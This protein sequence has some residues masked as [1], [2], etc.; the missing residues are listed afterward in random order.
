[1]K[2]INKPLDGLR[3]YGRKVA[4]EGIVLLENN[5]VLPLVN[6]K[7]ALFGRIQTNYYKSGTGS[8]GLV[9]VTDVPS[10]VDAVLENPRLDLN[11]DVLNK[12]ETWINENPFNAGNGMWASEPWSQV[13]ME[14]N[15]EE[16]RNLKRDDEIAVMVIG[17]TAGEDR[18]NFYGEGSYLLTKVEYNVIEN[19]KKVYEKVV[20]VLN[21]GN[22]IDLNF[23]KELNVDGLLLAWHGGQDGARAS[24]DVLTGYINPSG[25]L[26]VTIVKDL[27]KYEASKTFGRD[28]EIHYLEDIY[29]GYR[30]FESFLEEEVLYPFGYGL[31]Y[32]NFEI[33]LKEKTINNNKIN[34]T[35][36]VNNI[37]NYLGKE[38]VQIYYEAPQGL[39]GKPKK[40]LIAFSKTKTIKPNESVILKISFDI[41]QMASYDDLGLIKK[42]SYVLE[43]G[44]YIIYYGNSV[45]NNEVALKYNVVNNIITEELSEALA[46]YKSFERIKAIK[47]DNKL[48]YIFEKTP[49]RLINLDERINENLPNEIKQTRNNYKLIDV[50][51]NKITLDE[52]VGTLSLEDLSTIII[53]EGMSSPK[54]TPGTA[55][56]FAGVTNELVEKGIPTLAAA[57]GPSGIRMDS[58]MIATSLPNGT[59]IAA[60]FNPSLVTKLYELEG[61][62]MINYNIDCLLG[63]GMNIQRHPLNGRNF[64]YFSEDPLL[65]GIM[66]SAFVEGLNNVGVFGAMKHF[67]AN[68]QEKA[69]SLANSIISERALR[70]IYLKPF[71]I[72]VKSANANVIMTSYNPINGI[73]TA[74]NYDLNTTI[75]RNEW[76]FDGILMTDWWAMMNDDQ[77]EPSKENFKAL[78][79]SQNDLYMVVPNAKEYKSNLLESI[80]KGEVKL[81][82]L[83]RNAKN[84]LKFAMKSLTFRN[85]NNI[86]TFNKKI[87]NKWFYTNEES[88]IVDSNKIKTTYTKTFDNNLSNEFDLV[89]T[90]NDITYAIKDNNLFVYGI[91]EKKVVNEFDELLNNIDIN[92]TNNIFP[93][94][95]WDRLEL[96]LTSAIINNTKNNDW[97]NIEKDAIYTFPIKVN[98]FGKYIIELEISSNEEDIHQMPFSIYINNINKHTITTNGTNGNKIIT[99]GHLV[100]D[101]DS[102]YLSFKFH[103]TGINVYSIAIIKHG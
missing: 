7:I 23:V 11:L 70:E 42:S 31:S 78:V 20:V 53:G 33:E 80:E 76:G 61:L 91:K 36:N 82:E 28:D 40:E 49:E 98:T 47:K 35:F 15:E 8:G 44:E 32:T 16:I 5:G 25:K 6:K 24:I 14:I 103:K 29:V 12:Y 66:A 90:K 92:I 77:G 72:A 64:E 48:T 99:N 83:Q 87:V 21:V 13:E 65:T 41:N 94:K 56:A 54:V 73:W 68:N 4:H 22:V 101:E 19:L 1:M 55:A 39:L 58:G 18:D 26:P 10:F 45:R 52:F 89:E 97:F 81:S 74:G 69:R 50:Y 67:A 100:I 37:G 38:V 79:K 2:N 30:F 95:N 43:K 60:T 3:D 57:D 96:D 63:P 17:R 86:K 51:N 59:L 102:K 27:N 71:E 9:N 85:D 62:E 84:I 88:I 93:V 34:L 46:P 75:L